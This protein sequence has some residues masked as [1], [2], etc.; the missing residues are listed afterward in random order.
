[1]MRLKMTL[2]KCATGWLSVEVTENPAGRDSH[3]KDIY[4]SL[5]RRNQQVSGL[6]LVYQLHDVSELHHYPFESLVLL[7]AA[8]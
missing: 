4:F 5:L 1:M 6:G 7:M 2:N 3:T 8:K